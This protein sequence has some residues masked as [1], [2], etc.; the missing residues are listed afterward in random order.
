MPKA[1]PVAMTDLKLIALD[2]EDLA[3]V[4][5]LL[6]D[7]V[8]RVADMTYVPAQKAA[9][10]KGGKDGKDYRRQRTALRFDRVFGA[11]LKN[12]KPS[13]GDRILSLLAVSFE[14][15]DP[16]G[17]RVTLTFS[18]DASIQLEVECIEAELKD[19]GLVW[20]TRSRPE[21]PGSEPGD[22]GT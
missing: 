11:Q 5:S 19:L 12:V 22:A 6:Q 10:E 1:A 3:V 14:P 16:P 13:F 4:S 15:G 21:H 17:G 8:V 18:G 9:Q 2:E 7:A 20:R